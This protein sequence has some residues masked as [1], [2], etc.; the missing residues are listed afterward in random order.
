[1]FDMTLD[2]LLH[3][4]WLQLRVGTVLALVIGLGLVIAIVWI[5]WRG[6]NGIAALDNRCNTAARR[7]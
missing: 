5:L 3:F 4:D 1:M 7:F 6:N 2:Q